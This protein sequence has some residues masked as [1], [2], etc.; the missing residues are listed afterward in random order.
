[1][2]SMNEDDY[3]VNMQFAPKRLS[4][5]YKDTLKLEEFYKDEKLKMIDMHENLLTFQ[6]A[7]K[8]IWHPWG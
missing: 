2:L 8:K 4:I 3:D 5:G 6:M 7:G 1:M